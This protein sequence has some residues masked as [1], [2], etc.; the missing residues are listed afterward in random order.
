MAGSWLHDHGSV[1]VINKLGVG[2]N[3]KLNFKII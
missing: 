1:Q 3:E 2:K